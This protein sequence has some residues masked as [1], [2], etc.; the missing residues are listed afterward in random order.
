MSSVISVENLSNKYIIRHQ[1]QERYSAL[2]DVLANGAK[3]FTR[4]LR[5]PF[6]APKIDAAH[7]EFWALEGY[8]L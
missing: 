2:R 8:K 4:R 6:A 7:E 3:C 1:K 5:H